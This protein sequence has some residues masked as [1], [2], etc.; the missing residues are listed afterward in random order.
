MGVMSRLGTINRRWLLLAAGVVGGIVLIGA[1][2]ILAFRDRA[3]P[4]SEEE[5]AATLSIA[6]GSGE[7]GDPGLYRLA[8]TGFETTD[9]LGGSRHDFPAET[10]VTIQPG[11]CGTLVRWEALEQRW[12]EWEI[13][14]DGD[15]AGWDSYHQWYGVSNRDEWV[16]PEPIPTGGEP[17]D[18]WTG[19]CS[20]SDS[21][22]T[23]VYEV[24]GFET[25]TIA[26]E[27]VETLH[28]RV[29]SSIV[30]KTRGEATVDTWTLP[31]TPLVVR[32]F[33][34]RTSVTD[35]PIGA[36]EYHEEYEVVLTSLQP[37]S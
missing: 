8:T 5:V 6:P 29:T 16:C 15:L 25:L 13:C 14:A 31:G 4:V 18:T 35:S 32:R 28:L 27:E 2:I 30:G 34:E 36:V 1:V 24:V 19:V 23:R 7:P 17:G 22:E 3:T 37:R 33:V 10:Y 11:G 21:A 12:D 26:G 9:A 20:T